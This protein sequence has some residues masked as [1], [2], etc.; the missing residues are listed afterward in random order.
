MRRECAKHPSYFA[1][2]IW[3]KLIS[4]II[5]IIIIKRYDGRNKYRLLLL[6]LL[7]K[8][9]SLILNLLRDQFSQ[10][11]PEFSTYTSHLLLKLSPRQISNAIVHV[12][13]VHLYQ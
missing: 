10:Y 11:R 13:V 12:L 5:I 6:L 3:T 7:L 1:E 9:M 8:S 4:I 2:T